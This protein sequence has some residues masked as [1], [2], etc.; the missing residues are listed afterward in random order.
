MPPRSTDL[1]GD[2]LANFVTFSC[3]VALQTLVL[4]YPSLGAKISSY[5]TLSVIRADRPPARSFAR[6]SPDG[7]RTIPRLASEA[8]LVPVVNFGWFRRLEC[9]S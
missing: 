6:L 9:R 4:T 8:C 7:G 5:V 2:S 1:I 3:D